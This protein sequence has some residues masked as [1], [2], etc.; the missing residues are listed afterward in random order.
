[1]TKSLSTTFSENKHPSPAGRNLGTFTLVLES[2]S[3][4]ESLDACILQGAM[5]GP[6][7][8]LDAGNCFNPLRLTRQIRRQTLQIKQTLDH[9]QVARA[10][11]CYQVISLL[12]ETQN[13]RGPVFILRLMTSFADEMISVY[14]R[15]RLLKQVTEH[16]ERLRKTAPVTVMLKD[17][18]CQDEL[19]LDW[20]S[21]LRAQAD[22]IL[23]PELLIPLQPA[24][25]F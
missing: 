15:L 19:L 3:R 9:I 14:E 2:K 5:C 8:V 22:E 11:T 24:A 10:F 7:L 6:V 25:M 20:L 21:N 17:A 23:L 12:A 18:H 13:P 1:M 16:I 4:R